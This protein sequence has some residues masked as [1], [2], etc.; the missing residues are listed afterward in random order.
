[1]P[2][3]RFEINV[4]AL[5]FG[6]VTIDGDDVTDRVA[7]FHIEAEPMKP[8]E[9]WLKQKAGTLAIQGEGIVRVD[10]PEDMLEQLA[11]LIDAIDPEDL[12]RQA[13]QDPNLTGEEHALTA[14][15][16]RK[17]TEMLRARA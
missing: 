13:L 6:R 15:M 2:L 1:M 7:G 16:L 3:S 14:A 5:G 10:P 8:T 17:I 9:V 12:E 4:D 11:S